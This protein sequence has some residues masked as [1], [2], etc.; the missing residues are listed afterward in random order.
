MRGNS[1]LQR[2]RRV[3]PASR[4]IGSSRRYPACRTTGSPSCASTTSQH[5]QGW[6]D[7][8][9][10]HALLRE[11]EPFIEEF[12]ARVV[13]SGFEQ[14]FTGGDGAAARAPVWKQNMVVLLM[15]YPVVFLFGRYVQTPFLMG[16]AGLP[17]WA[18]LFIGNVVSVIVAELAG[19]VGVPGTRLVAQSTEAD[20]T[21]RR[22]WWRGRGMRALLCHPVCV[23]HALVV[24]MARISG[25]RRS[26][27]R[28]V[29]FPLTS[30][31]VLCAE[32]EQQVHGQ[33]FRRDASIAASPRRRRRFVR[34]S[35][36]PRLAQIHQARERQRRWCHRR[37]RQHAAAPV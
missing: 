28:R 6:L 24:R 12:H 35:R 19:A 25:C 34:A 15:L 23:L 4:A 11:A 5:L 29:S 7:A 16:R 31:R 8:P 2:R 36:I 21:C 26:G 3:R 22:Y 32:S 27:S 9:E 18:A 10:R 1:A 30:R 14:W 13:R 33:G 17:F 20:A 37:I